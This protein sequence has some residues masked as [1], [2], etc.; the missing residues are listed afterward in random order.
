M[1]AIAPAVL[2]ELYA[3]A[4]SSPSAEVCGV[5]GGSDDRID[6]LF[7]V[8]NVAETPRTRFVM[9]SRG[10]MQALKAVR[11]AGQDH[12][13]FYHS[14]THTS[15]YPSPT[16]VG[17]WTDTWGPEALCF[18]CSLADFDRPV[19]RAFRIDWDGAITEEP[20]ETAP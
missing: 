2:E 1:V 3:H 9:D 11:E 7:K 14:H 10:M 15:A 6:S 4:Q 13:G 20:V 8:D 12:M 16:D 5:L 19:L 17:V 18:I